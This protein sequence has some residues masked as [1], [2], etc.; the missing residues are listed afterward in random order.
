MATFNP[1]NV[2]VMESKTGEIPTE[3]G[4]LIIKKVIDDSVITKLAKY[5]PMTKP[6]KVFSYLAEG[7]GAYWVGEAEKI[8]TSSAK[9]LTVTMEAKKLGVIL[10]VSKE[11]LRYSVTDFFNIMKPEIAKAFQTK[12]DQAAVFGIDSPYQTG[13]SIYERAV[14]AENVLPQ[15]GDIYQDLNGLIS[16]IEDGD[17]EAEAFITTRKFNRELRAA[18]DSRSIPIFNEVRDGVTNQ[19]LGLPISYANKNAWDYTKAALITGEFDSARYGIL[20]NIEYAIS[21]DATLSTITDESGDPINL[22]ERDMFALRA[23][24]HIGFLTIKDDAFA[25]LQPETEGEGA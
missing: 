6:K 8:Q 14:T 7:P 18:V 12:F 4:D 2:M 24:M 10:P 19:V 23:T 1:K 3:Q 5:E 20:Q 11:F 25:V 13:I 22:F 21:E 16:L 17:N 9:W 15:S